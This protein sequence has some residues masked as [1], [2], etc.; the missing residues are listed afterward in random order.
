MG[1][2]AEFPFE[3]KVKV[4]GFRKYR[5]IF[6]PSRDVLLQRNA[7]LLRGFPCNRIRRVFQEI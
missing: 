7:L 2:K 3:V 4:E 6:G 5:G 1:G